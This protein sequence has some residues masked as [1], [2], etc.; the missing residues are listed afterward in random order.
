[1]STGGTTA[2][3]VELS[4]ATIG[5]INTAKDSIAAAT[6]ADGAVTT[7]QGVLAQDQ[8]SLSNAQANQ[9]AAHQKASSDALAALQA[10]EQ[11]LGLP[12]TSPA[13]SPAKATA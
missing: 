13:A 10:V 12:V 9:T 8:Q 6:T 7:A 11:E 3:A 1:M 2:P 4:P 5:L